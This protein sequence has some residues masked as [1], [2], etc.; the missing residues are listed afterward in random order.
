MIVEDFVND[1]GGFGKASRFLT[2]K[3]YTCTPSK[4]H[5]IVAGHR[6][7]SICLSIQIELATKGKVKALD[8]LKDSI[9]Y[10]KTHRK[11]V[12]GMT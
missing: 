5:H 11:E 10:W 3:G 8:V 9:E 7:A 12:I 4:L 6:S 1:H 2:E